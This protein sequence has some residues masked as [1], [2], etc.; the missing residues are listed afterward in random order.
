MRAATPLLQNLFMGLLL[1][2]FILQGCA[3][4]NLDA[5]PAVLSYPVTPGPVSTRDARHD[6]RLRIMTLNMAHGRGDG[7]HQ[8]LQGTATTRANLDAIAALLRESG[9]AV[10][11][12]QEA[13]GPSFWSGNFNHI[14][15]VAS[16]GDFSQSVHGT[17]AN[18]LGL[19]YGTALISSVDLGNPKAITFDPALSPVPKGFV[20]S[21]II[22]PGMSGIAVDV[23][24]VHLDFASEATRKRQARVL[25]ETLRERNRPVILMGDFNAGWERDST[26]QY[27]SRELAL[28]AYR[29]EDKGLET[30]PAF[31][32]R[33]DWILVSPE[34]AFHS[35][36]VVS[37]TVSDH[38]GVLA[39]LVLNRPI[40]GSDLLKALN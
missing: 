19:S 29:P 2:G 6:G 1:P 14:G 30:F 22:W 26:V 40:K 24:S 15:Y 32:E 34:I 25:I 28:T 18:G 20:V 11:A 8:L 23:V 9:A 21:T 36:R 10:V 39:E 17:H 12:L 16:N 35:Y 38:R 5:T 3:T 27:I 33:L 13:D 4:G 7:I 31:G 37:K